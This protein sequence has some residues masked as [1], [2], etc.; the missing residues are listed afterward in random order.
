MASCAERTGK[1]LSRGAVPR[2]LTFSRRTTRRVMRLLL[3]PLLFA[4]G[5]VEARAALTIN[6]V[7]LNG[8]PSVMVA[9]G[10]TI[11]ATITVTTDTTNWRSTAWRIANTPPGPTTCVNHP[12]HDGNFLTFSETFNITAP[13]TEGTYNAYFVAGSDNSCGGTTTLATLS[14]GVVVNAPPTVS[15]INRASPDP[16]TPGASVSWTVT[17]S[18]A[19]TGV[20]AGDFALVESGLSGSAIT[21]VSG[22]G[23]SWTVTATV[24]WGDGA[25]G[26]NLVDNDTIRDA[27]AMP[28]GGTGAGNGNFTGQA[29]SVPFTCTPP[30]GTPAGA[31]C[32]CDTF[33]RASLN[34]STIFGA[35]WIVSTSDG[36]GILPSIVGNRLRLTNNTGNN[37]KAA[38][39]P[40]IFPAAGNYMS[41]DFRYYAYNGSSADG[42]AVVLSDYSVPA[43][44]GGYGG[45]LG[46]ALRCGINGFAGGWLG[47]GIDEYGNFRNDEECRGDGPP[48]SG[49]V[50]Q[51]VSVRGSGAGLTGYRWHAE[52]GALTPRIDVPG[53]TP[54]PGH[55]YRIVVDHSNGVN[56]WTRVERD[57]GGGFASVIG[58]Y[59][60]KARPGQAAVPT[61]WQ[62]SLTGSTGG[63]TNYHEIDNLRVCATTV[64]PPSGG[65]ASGFSAIDEAYG[66]PPAVAVQNYL[67]GH[68]YLKLVGQPFKLDVAA[69]SNNQIMTSYVVSGSKWVQLKLVD[70]SDGACVLDSSQPGYCSSACVNKTAVGGGSQVLTYA[71][72]N[73]GQKQS[74]DF[75]INTA[76][77]HL[78]AIMRE[79]TT[80]A[81]AAFTATPAACSTDSFAVRPL[82]LTAA[83]NATQAGT[84]GAPIFRAG[85]DNFTVSATIP[86]IAG[87]PSGYDG[88][89][90]IGNQ[91]A[92]APATQLGG[93][94]PTT[95]PAAT[96]GTPNAGATGSFNYSEVGGVSLPGYA[97]A[98]TDTRLRGIWDDTWGAVDAD[99]SKNDCVAGS[100][101]NTRDTSGSFATNPNYGKYGCLFGLAVPL[102]LGRFVPHHFDTEIPNHAC[103]NAFTYS[104]QP[105]ELKVTARNAAGATTQNYAGALAKAGTYAEGNG[106]TGSFSPAALP[107]ASF[108]AGVADL[109]A[110]PQVAFAYANKLTAPST[111]RLR[112]TDADGISSSAGSEGTTPLRS[113]RLLISNAHGSEL[114]G[115]TMPIQTQ[116]WTGAAWTTNTLDS[117]SDVSTW[118]V[119]DKSPGGMPSPSGG[120]ISNGKGMLTFAAPNLRGSVTVCANVGPDPD[121]TQ[122]N[123]RSGTG[124][125][126]TAPSWLQGSWDADGLYND[127]PAARATFG[128]YEQ[129]SPIIYRR[130]RY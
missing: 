113:G 102:T 56:A 124:G 69:L 27:Q 28:L 3:I 75:T 119:F 99:P 72:A 22:S 5:V 92:I 98:A 93:F 14:N 107:A 127:N 115:L 15:A 76:Y 125:S 24:G 122:T 100:F 39:L 96:P 52:S 23:A 60:A 7:T 53:A 86:G 129:K 111:L 12:N 81:C 87:N 58:Q 18:E 82:S 88:V 67:T 130:E 118:L 16:T 54:G 43:V 25:L 123:C 32:V 121:N 50:P 36:T 2:R 17:F 74:A 31:T 65:T 104:G 126:G 40:A 61:N 33:D 109:T 8:A 90:R 9:P 68:I 57:T 116:Y 51:S 114:L 20:D 97:P 19:V 77:K 4:L 79:C 29:Y 35:N 110:T 101:S 91:T 26:L 64:W 63:S 78:A 47:V 11:S 128:I 71:P 80:A 103:S 85:S 6:S 45:S 30:P 41:V 105:F 73:Q 117:C 95:F 59:D 46:Y 66:T 120:A 89:L 44:P 21:G 55:R 37:A 62:L 34:P 106:A 38:T 42:V 48:P 1:I 83:T 84:G 112:V 49:L 13:A 10:A 70:N 94:A 108:S